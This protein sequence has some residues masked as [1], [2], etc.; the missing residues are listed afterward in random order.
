MS[1]SVAVPLLD[2]KPQYLALK[3]ELDAAVANVI[4]S[5]YFI[6]G[7]TVEKFETACAD[8]CNTQHAIGVSSGTDA[9]IVAMMAMGI[10]EGDEV[11]TSPYTFFGTAGSITRLGAKPVFVDIE[12][13]TFNIDVAKIEAVITDKTRAIAPVHLFGQMADMRAINRLAREHDLLVIEDAAQ[14][15]GAKQHGHPACSFGHMGCLSFFPTK[16]LGGFGDGGMVLC[17]DAEYAGIIRQ[18]R[19]H[20]MEPKYFH[21]RVGGNFRLDALQAAVLDVKLKHL[22]HWH[23][24]RRA[25]AAL[26]HKLASEAGISR[27]ISLLDSGDLQNGISLPTEKDGNYHIY[28]QFVIY[29]DQRDALIDHLR[30]NNVGC[31]IYY[32]LALHEQECFRLLGYKRGDFPNSERAAAMSLALPIFPDLAPEQI[33]RVVEVITDFFA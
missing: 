4:A 20:G 21:A 6:L 10:G 12:P 26:Y 31:E 17:D 29:S 30:A 33:T 18:L 22:N 32:P 9:L 7:P 15:I 16:N 27:D 2:L 25:N 1:D 3:P 24:Q 28:N 5:Q 11:I 8:Y 13:S 23:E 19:N 14:A